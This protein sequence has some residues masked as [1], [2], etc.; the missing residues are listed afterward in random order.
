MLRVFAIAVFAAA[1]LPAGAE[2]A[3]FRG[4]RSSHVGSESGGKG[5]GGSLVVAPRIGH[6]S[7]PGDA[8]SEAP[9][10]VPFPPGS[11][12]EPALRLTTADAPKLWCRSQVVVGGFCML[13]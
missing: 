13:N 5:S 6:S 11:A 8:A 4:G 2:A 12:A 10:R 9:A 3:K 1:L 7:R